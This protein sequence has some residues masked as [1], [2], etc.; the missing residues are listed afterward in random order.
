MN[1]TIGQPISHR[2]DHMLS[3]T[4]AN[5]A[6]KIFGADLYQLRSLAEQ[7]RQSMQ[8]VAGVV[9]LSVEQQT[10]VPVLKIKFDRAE[11][12]RHGLT[13]RDVARTVEASLQGVKASRVLEGQTAYD[14][15]VRLVT[16]E[17]W[18]LETLG[19]LLVDTP[20]GARVPL[21]SLARIQR[22]TGPNQILREQVERKIVVQCNV[23]GRDVTGVVNDIQELVNPIIGEA[24]SYRVEYAGQFE[25]AAEA[26]RTL[27]LVSLAVIIGIGFLLH[28][29]FRSARDA[30]LIMLNLPL[31]LIGGVAG[32]FVSGGVLSVASLIGFITVFGIATRNGIMLVS[33]IRHLQEH[34][35]VTDF[36]EAVRRGAMERLV[37]IMM[38]A[39]AAGLALIPL[40]LGGDKPGNEIQTPMAIVILFGLLTSMVLNMIIV[41]AM[42]LRFG[43]P[44]N[45]TT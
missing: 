31:A 38:T 40:A 6:V 9:D 11:I 16:A 36:R 29:A 43:R 22:D 23:A 13:I 33:H 19:N 45:Q 41:P 26:S 5:I 3:G 10:E 39:L 18:Q 24:A 30:A 14:L 25:S 28:L 27:T 8:G 2:I 32:V 7:A 42:Y 21:R 12:A 1:I 4:R 17:E 34:E 15:V 37:P 44:V 20:A 35:G